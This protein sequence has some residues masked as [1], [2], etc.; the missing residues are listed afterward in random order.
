MTCAD[1]DSRC[2][3]RNL[4]Q[5]W[6]LIYAIIYFTYWPL[7]SLSLY[8]FCFDCCNFWRQLLSARL[9]LLRTLLKVTQSCRG[10]CYWSDASW[11]SHY[12]TCLSLNFYRHLAARMSDYFSHWLCSCC[13]RYQH[14]RFYR[15]LNLF[16]RCYTPQTRSSSW[17]QSCFV[18]LSAKQLNWSAWTHETHWPAYLYEAFHP[19][20]ASPNPL[21][22]AVECDMSRALVSGTRGW[23]VGPFL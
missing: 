17:L 23:S 13:G 6:K 9:S 3:L 4:Y 7:S 18:R 22:Y 1:L 2:I 8:Y 16:D 10:S 19:V 5:T 21:E 14:H 12:S 11:P 20:L 15:Y